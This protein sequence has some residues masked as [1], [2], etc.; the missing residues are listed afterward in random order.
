MRCRHLWLFVV[1]GLVTASSGL[2]GQSPVAV[3]PGDASK[4]ALV[5]A[6]CPTFSWGEVDGATS[7]ELVVYRLGEEGEE[8]RPVLGETFAGSASSWT[9]SLDRCL[10]RGGQYA[11][12][13]R[14]VGRK[15][16]SEWSVP[17]LFEVASGPSESEFE[18]AL[19]LVRQYLGGDTIGGAGVSA[20]GAEPV[21]PR[22]VEDVGVLA[23]VAD[24]AID[25]GHEPSV[26]G[27]ESVGVAALTVAGEVRTVTSSD[28]PRLWGKGREGTVRYGNL[29]GLCTNGSVRFGLSKI[30]VEWGS[31][32]DACPAGTWVCTNAER[33]FA[34]CNT[35]RA[36]SSADG[37]DCDGS[38]FNWLPSGHF[39]W[40][41]DDWGE[42]EGLVWRE[43]GGAW[44]VRVCSSLP[45]WCCDYRVSIPIPRSGHGRPKPA[46]GGQ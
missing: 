31:A 17:S 9:P 18:E 30:A 26:R 21:G 44:S 34:A 40:V 3:S 23:G 16:A 10:E 14:A 35:I 7:Y 38:T 45:V 24:V 19:E 37:L 4:L 36:D 32:A 5:E 39:G 22:Q 46:R 8:A 2:A 6:R 1:A 42:I 29:G 33:G 25:Q 27:L 13:V 11:W 15:E 43:N 12:S 41:A 28:A 20:E